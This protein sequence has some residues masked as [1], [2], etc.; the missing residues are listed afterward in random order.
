MRIRRAKSAVVVLSFLAALALAGSGDVSAAA[1]AASI[2]VPISGTVDGGPES[3]S[4]SGS[5]QIA[6]TLVADTTA[7]TRK[8]RLAIKLVNG[9]GVGLTSGATYIAAGEDR[10]LRPLALSDHLD[11]LFPFFRATAG[12]RSARSAMASMTLRF[13]LRTG[14]LASATAT[15]SSPGLAG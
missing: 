9:S 2:T 15:F 3:V 14:S 5:L 12:A 10:L 7:T 11:V 8:V 6:S 1:P 13:D 4:L